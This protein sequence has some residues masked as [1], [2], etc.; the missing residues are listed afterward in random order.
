MCDTEAYIYLPLLEEMD[1]MPE[2]KYAS[3]CE[4]RKYG[5]SIAK[6]YGLHA[7]AQFQSYVKTVTWDATASEW[8][9]T[10]SEE[11]KG[12]EKSIF[13]LHADNV[14]FASGELH[15]IDTPYV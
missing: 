5:E 4:I 6:K 12:G 14:I 2:H 15:Q 11:P 1:Y 3:G 9:T 7:R 13:T 8:V 10:I